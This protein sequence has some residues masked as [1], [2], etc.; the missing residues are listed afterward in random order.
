VL[1]PATV[2]V[3]VSLWHG[4]HETATTLSQVT[5]LADAAP[6]WT[7]RSTPG[8]SAVLGSWTAILD[9]AARSFPGVAAA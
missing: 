1:D 4:K 2:R 8:S 6:G 3:P 9:G 7:V 5:T